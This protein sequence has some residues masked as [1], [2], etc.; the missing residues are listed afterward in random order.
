[1]TIAEPCNEQI[2]M[3]FFFLNEQI[4]A[5]KDITVKSDN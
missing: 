5:S 2:I 1:M 4:K 3:P